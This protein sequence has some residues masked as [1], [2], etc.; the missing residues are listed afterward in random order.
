MGGARTLRR[1]R[2]DPNRS[3]PDSRMHKLTGVPM[4]ANTAGWFDVTQE[5][6]QGCVL[7]T[8]LFNIDFAAVIR[9]V[10]EDRDLSRDLF[11]LE[12]DLG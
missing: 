4:T 9:A 5:L 1:T 11:H 2:K 10:L 3:P 8:L 6:R 12:K 7:F